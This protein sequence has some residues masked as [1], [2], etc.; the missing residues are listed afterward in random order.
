V[1]TAESEVLPRPDLQG[2][3][4]NVSLTVLCENTAGRPGIL[5]E[6]GLSVWIEVAGRKVLLDTGRQYA[7]AH[8]AA[9]LG[10]NL[11]DADAL[12]LSHGHV[13]H[14]GGV[15]TVLAARPGIPVF[16]HPDSL[17]QRYSR[18]DALGL[19]AGAVEAVGMAPETRAALEAT[20][21]LHFVTGPTEVVPFLWATGPVPRREPSEGKG[22][23]GYLD[24]NASQ[25]D[26]IA[27]DMALW[28]VTRAGLLV[29]LGCAHSGLINT[30]RH[31]QAVTGGAPITGVV[32]GTHLVIASPER[33]DATIDVLR[34]LPLRLLAPC[35][36]TGPKEVFRLREAFPR[37]SAAMSSGLR[38]VFP[39]PTSQEA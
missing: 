34:K 8:N 17:R 37:Q 7:L 15:D 13:D 24:R 18:L 14:I 31:I 22:G 33:V 25:P 11:A 38:L 29:V 35:H 21:D 6:W 3:P 2:A 1:S 27:G 23:L 5:G 26:P 39:P 9:K 4:E 36:C 30:I 16:L 12:V 20:A 10:V 28:V 19:E 32:G